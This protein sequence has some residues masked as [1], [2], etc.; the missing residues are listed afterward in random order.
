MGLIVF[1]DQAF[2]DRGRLGVGIPGYSGA[3]GYTPYDVPTKVAARYFV[4]EDFSDYDDQ[5]V[6]K[7]IAQGNKW[8]G[9][10]EVYRQRVYAAAKKG[11]KDL[12][13][14][15]KDIDELKPRVVA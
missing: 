12:G 5:D 6:Q 14:S 13:F 9:G 2:R 7:P 10:K 4:G 15:N 3:Q 8:D 11:G 1:G